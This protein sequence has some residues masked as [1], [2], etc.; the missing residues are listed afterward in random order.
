MTFEDLLIEFRK[1]RGIVL[2]VCQEQI[3]L[4][5]IFSIVILT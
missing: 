5:M 2:N 1:R 4:H 3:H